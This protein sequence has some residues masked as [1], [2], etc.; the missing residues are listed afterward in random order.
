MDEDLRKFKNNLGN[1]IL[2]NAEKINQNNIIPIPLLINNLNG[3]I[4]KNPIFFNNQSLNSIINEE[5]RAN[6]IHFLNFLYKNLQTTTYFNLSDTSSNFLSYLTSVI[7]LLNLSELSHNQTSTNKPKEFFQNLCEPS[8]NLHK[9]NLKTN[10]ININYIDNQLNQLLNILFETKCSEV[11][12]NYEM[13]NQ[14]IT[15]KQLLDLTNLKLDY[16]KNLNEN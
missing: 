4:D 5:N 14:L 12:K 3:E 16:L 7:D 11:I 15:L 8:L 13:K 2:K 6:Y 1:D 9:S 10:F